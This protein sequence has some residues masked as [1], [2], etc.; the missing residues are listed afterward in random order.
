MRSPTSASPQS[1]PRPG[2]MVE[3]LR[4]M[5]ELRAQPATM[6]R[7]HHL[8][9]LQAAR[10]LVRLLRLQF[11]NKLRLHKVMSALFALRKPSKARLNP[12]LELAMSAG[13]WPLRK[14]VPSAYVDH[15]QDQLLFRFNNRQPQQTKTKKKKSSNTASTMSRATLR[16]SKIQTSTQQQNQECQQQEQERQHHQ[17]QHIFVGFLTI[18]GGSGSTVAVLCSGSFAKRKHQFS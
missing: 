16:S 13:W 17:R 15:Q 7:V 6:H 18:D 3:S 1:I 9:P 4:L 2:P 11:R 8:A 14:A 10:R 5:Q 12:Y